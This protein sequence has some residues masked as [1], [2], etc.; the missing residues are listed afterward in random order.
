[1]KV[2]DYQNYV[3]TIIEEF[4]SRPCTHESFAMFGQKQTSKQNS[5]VSDYDSEV[6]NDQGAFKDRTG[7]QAKVH[8][9]K[10][11]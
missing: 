7:V 1:M 11:F 2:K 10:V 3:D 8:F 5:F 9:N 4:Q 6:S